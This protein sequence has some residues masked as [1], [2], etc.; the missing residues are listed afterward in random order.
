MLKRQ[1]L[2][3]HLYGEQAELGSKRKIG[4]KEPSHLTPYMNSFK[5]CFLDQNLF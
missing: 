3:D 4:V 1:Y 5:G 2:Q